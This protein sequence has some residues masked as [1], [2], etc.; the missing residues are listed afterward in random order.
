[1]SHLT[2]LENIGGDMNKVTFLFLSRI[3]CASG[4]IFA[5]FFVVSQSGFTDI[6]N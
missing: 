2:D 4:I 5:A 6:Y 1:M 3:R